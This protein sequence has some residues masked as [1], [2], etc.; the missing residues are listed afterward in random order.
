MPESEFVQTA[1]RII[2]ER[3]EVFDA[4]L[5]FERTKKLP[6]VSY[7]QRVNFTID[8]KVYRDFRSF[9]NDHNISMSGMIEGFMRKKLLSGSSSQENA[10]KH[11]AMD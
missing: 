5:E 6:K 10:E 11:L 3:P 2:Q 1:K 7:K 8:S 9:C 4:L